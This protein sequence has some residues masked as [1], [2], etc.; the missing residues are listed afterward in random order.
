MRKEIFNIRVIKEQTN[1]YYYSSS[2]NN[3][4]FFFLSFFLFFGEGCF[5]HL[6][7]CGTFKKNIGDE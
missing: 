6:D 1:L 7:K 2:L 3:V 4:H 5:I